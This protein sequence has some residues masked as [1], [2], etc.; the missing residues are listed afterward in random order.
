[1][2]ISYL[3]LLLMSVNILIG[4]IF[5]LKNTNQHYCT[6]L[7]I[8]FYICETRF[9]FTFILLLASAKTSTETINSLSSTLVPI[10]GSQSCLE[11]DPTS[12]LT[13]KKYHYN[14]HESSHFRPN[15]ILPSSLALGPDI[16]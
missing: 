11:T 15:I 6:H 2:T 7:G 12:F 10:A 9:K 16:P 5:K 4:W 3:L 8:G 1:M 13:A 14:S